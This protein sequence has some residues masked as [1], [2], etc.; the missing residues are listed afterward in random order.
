[1]I[2]NYDIRLGS[3]AQLYDM[4][5]RCDNVQLW[6]MM[7]NYDKQLRQIITTCIFTKGNYYIDNYN[8]QLQYCTQL[9]C[10]LVH[11]A[12]TSSEETQWVEIGLGAAVDIGRVDEG[13]DLV[14]LIAG[15]QFAIFVRRRA[16][17][18]EIEARQVVQTV[19]RIVAGHLDRHAIRMLKAF[20]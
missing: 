15:A 19:E 7:Y 5:L 4:Q 12:I 13:G 1:M 10:T 8:E 20:S 6:L 2:N 14:D 3:I 9:W 11:C 18:D 17:T 16:R